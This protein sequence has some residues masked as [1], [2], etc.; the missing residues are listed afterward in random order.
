MARQ[1]E[2][3]IPAIEKYGARDRYATTLFYGGQAGS[4]SLRSGNSLSHG[5]ARFTE[6]RPQAVLSEAKTNGNE[7]GR[8][9]LV[10][11]SRETRESPTTSSVPSP[12]QQVVDVNGDA[13]GPTYSDDFRRTLDA[14]LNGRTGF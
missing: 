3:Q 12:V 13:T 11:L 1:K 10:V 8:Q 14:L 7:N 4:S 6:L 5:H 2:Q 9:D